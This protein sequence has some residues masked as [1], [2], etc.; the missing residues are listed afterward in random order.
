MVLYVVVD[1]TY[2]SGRESMVLEAT[3]PDSTT[4]ST[5]ITVT[6]PTAA[7]SSASTFAVLTP[8]AL[9]VAAAVAL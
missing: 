9:A 7:K 4:G 6:D 1:V 2:A 3:S 5:T 8:L